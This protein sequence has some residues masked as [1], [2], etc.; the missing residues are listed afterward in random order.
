MRLF[1][2]VLF[3]FGLTA[4]G[5]SGG[6]NGGG[7][8]NIAPVGSAQFNSL[9]YGYANNIC[10]STSTIGTPASCSVSGTPSNQTSSAT[11]SA[12]TVKVICNVGGNSYALVTS[13]GSSADATCIAAGGTVQVTCPITTNGACTSA[14]GVWTAANYPSV[15]NPTD[16]ANAGGIFYS[17]LQHL[18]GS[19]PNANLS[20]GN[21][22]VSADPNEVATVLGLF[23]GVSDLDNTNLS[24]VSMSATAAIGSYWEHSFY[25]SGAS[26][27]N[28]RSTSVEFSVGSPISTT[29]GA[30]TI[31]ANSATL[32]Y[33]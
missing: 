21:N 15:S 32:Y 33:H 26:V 16:C 5:G 27:Y 14:S 29:S 25:M 30:I 2:L 7:S 31:K 10:Y 23:N 13:G 8:G 18:T 22:V 24:L 20:A 19:M 17:T 11:C 4:C 12:G 6:G 3:V 28:F 1:I 9:T